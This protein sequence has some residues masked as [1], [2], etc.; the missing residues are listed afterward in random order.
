M[1]DA[2]Q[3]TNLEELL[4]A[5]RL[6]RIDRNHEA[7]ATGACLWCDQALNGPVRFCNSDCRND[8]DREKKAHKRNG[9]RK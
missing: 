5:A 9:G 3:A 2:D 8:W 4:S 1:D 6:A 7:K